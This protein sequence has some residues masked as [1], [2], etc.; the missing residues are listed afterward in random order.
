MTCECANAAA[1]GVA[2]CDT[3][4]THCC[5][6]AR[7]ACERFCELHQQKW[8]GRFVPEGAAAPQDTDEYGGR[9]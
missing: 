9:Q 3:E 8:T 7:T 5:V 1:S 2:A 4:Q 6:S